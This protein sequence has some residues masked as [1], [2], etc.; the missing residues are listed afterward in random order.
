VF[1]DSF[2][3]LLL[4]TAIFKL[5]LPFWLDCLDIAKE[6]LDS[7]IIDYLP[8]EQGESTHIDVM[9]EVVFGSVQ[10]SLKEKDMDNPLI[11]SVVLKPDDADGLAEQLKKI[12]QIARGR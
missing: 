5:I 3:L 12:S 4:A 11:L 8:K 2:V 6:C 10:L 9:I 1:F 7:L